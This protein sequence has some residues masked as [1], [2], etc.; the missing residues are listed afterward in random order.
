MAQA[1]G[2]LAGLVVFG[3]PASQERD[4]RGTSLWKRAAAIPDVVTLYDRQGAEIDRFGGSVSGETLLYDSQGRL[5]FHGGITDARGHEGDSTGMDALVSLV[6]GESHAA[7]Q[8][9]VFGCSL[10]DPGPQAL[11]DEPAWKKR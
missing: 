3:K 2:K 9:P 5:M 6:Q 8:S 1:H 11:E 4:V 10:R 7:T